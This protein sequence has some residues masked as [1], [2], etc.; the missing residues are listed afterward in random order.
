MSASLCWSDLE[1]GQ[2]VSKLLALADVLGGDVQQ[3]PGG[4]HRPGSHHRPLADQM[5]GH[6]DPAAVR[7]A[8]DVVT[9]GPNIVV[10]HL[11]GSHAPVAEGVQSPAVDPGRPGI[12][13]EHGD[14]AVL[15]GLR[16]GANGHHG[17]PGVAHAR[18]EDLLPVDEVVVSVDDGPGLDRGR[19]GPRVRLGHPYGEHGP[20]R[21]QLRDPPLLLSGGA[22]LEKE[23]QGV[24]GPAYQVP[25]GQVVIADF[26]HEAHD[27]VLVT[28]SSLLLGKADRQVS[29]VAEATE[30]GER[31]L[32]ALVQVTDQLG[33]RLLLQKSPQRAKECRVFALIQRWHRSVSSRVAEPDLRRPQTIALATR[34]PPRAE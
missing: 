11:V 18:G 9:V 27:V 23:L 21:S 30:Q 33:R 32:V 19:V 17:Q 6:H 24:H 16:V 15:L 13:Q 4:A 7:L 1:V 34:S 12:D 26:L 14:T 28:L 3:A 10:E 8:E 25:E 5:A 20:P 31:R 29:Q 22:E 2:R